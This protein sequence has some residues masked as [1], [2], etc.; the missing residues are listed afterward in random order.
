MKK[1]IRQ[2]VI[3]NQMTD[4]YWTNTSFYGF[5]PNGKV[6]HATFTEDLTKAQI[7]TSLK[8]VK[9]TL[10]NLGSFY[11]VNSSEVAELTWAPIKITYEI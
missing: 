5:G 6:F 10:K 4:K 7:F 1:S 8:R 9:K 2:Y 11:F 3:T